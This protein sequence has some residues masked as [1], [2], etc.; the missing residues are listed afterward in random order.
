MRLVKL[1]PQKYLRFD[2]FVFL[3]FYQQFYTSVF[4]LLGNILSMSE[5]KFIRQKLS[6]SYVTI[7]DNLTSDAPVDAGVEQIKTINIQ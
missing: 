2:A 3:F 7:S 1:L 4:M 5:H 6:L